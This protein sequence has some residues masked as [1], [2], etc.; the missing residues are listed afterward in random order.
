MTFL[1]RRR[2]AKAAKHFFNRLLKRHADEPRKIVTDVLLVCSSN[3][4]GSMPVNLSIPSGWLFKHL[5]RGARA[6]RAKS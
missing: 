4:Y 3:N 6:A 5:L 2:D 1:Q